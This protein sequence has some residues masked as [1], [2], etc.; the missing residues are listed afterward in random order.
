MLL[1]KRFPLCRKIQ[2]EWHKLDLA[3]KSVLL[4]GILLLIQLICAV[5]IPALSSQPTI[6]TIFQTS[7]SSIFGYILGMN[8]PTGTKS[9]SEKPCPCEEK[10]NSHHLLRGTNI[11]IFFTAAVCF[12]CLITLTIYTMIGGDVYN[13]GIFQIGHLVSSTIGFLISSSSKSP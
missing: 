3:C 4:I 5:F 8:I 9:S 10:E 11:H 2:R 1:K 7:L 12:T 13:D 6:N